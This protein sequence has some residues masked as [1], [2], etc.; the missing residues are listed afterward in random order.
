MVLGFG[1][2]S[3][4]RKANV[5]H[6][7]SSLCSSVLRAIERR[8]QKRKDENDNEHEHDW[9]EGREGGIPAS[10]IWRTE[11]CAGSVLRRSH[12]RLAGRRGPPDQ[13]GYSVSLP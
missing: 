6:S 7:A 13:T 4:V 5:A 11:P 2:C 3:I 1:R 10:T 9:E 12:I 8:S